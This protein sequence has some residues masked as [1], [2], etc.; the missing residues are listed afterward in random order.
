MILSIVTL[1]LLG[2]ALLVEFNRTLMLV[3]QN[4]YR[5]KR[6]R[7]S[8]AA[9]D[10]SM[11]FPHSLCMIV[12]LGSAIRFV[13]ENA[14]LVTYNIFAL[15]VL[16]VR[17]R[18]RRGYKHPLV[19]TARARRIYAAMVA[20]ALIVI[21]L[22][23]L[24][25]DSGTYTFGHTYGFFILVMWFKADWMAIAALWILKP[26]EKIINQRYIN[27]AKRILAS[28][29]DLKVIGIT[30]SYGKTSTKHYLNRILSEQFAV[31]MTPGSFNTTLG[32]VRTIRE[33]LK[34]FDQIF[35]CE[36]GA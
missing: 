3:Q 19:W 7:R 13:P 26:V 33:Y 25:P 14:F 28:M 22:L 2:L 36:M 21:G 6:F 15:A 23:S 17:L 11:S 4:S 1:T 27:D 34:P 16:I 8:L 10:D 29:P 18:E 9:M 32:V 30:G 31:C 24:V 5:I 12:I 35:I 20:L